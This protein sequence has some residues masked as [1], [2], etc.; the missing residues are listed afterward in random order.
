MIMNM[1]QWKMKIEPRIKL[2]YSIDFMLGL[3]S[4]TFPRAMVLKV[5]F[6][7]DGLVG[8]AKETTSDPPGWGYGVGL[9]DPTCNIY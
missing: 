9:I 2:N 4:P 6:H 3:T 1:K 5:G 8:P 7:H